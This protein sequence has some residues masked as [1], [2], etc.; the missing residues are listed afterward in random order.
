M[1]A[2]PGQTLIQTTMGLVVCRPMG[3]PI[4]SGCTE[5]HKRRENV[6]GGERVD[7]RRNYT[8]N[9]VIMMFVCGCYESELCVW[10]IRGVFIL[11]YSVEKPF[12]HGS[13]R[14]GDKHTLICPKET[15][16]CNCLD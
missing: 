7:V 12:L 3:L 1:T 14:N 6:R 10:V 5:V 9:K 13:K 4:T 16:V 11:T 8:T 2:Y 15:L